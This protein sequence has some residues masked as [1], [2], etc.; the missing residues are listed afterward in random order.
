MH[1]A[2]QHAQFILLTISHDSNEPTSLECIPI[3]IGYVWNE[4]RTG[5]VGSYIKEVRHVTSKTSP[6]H[7]LDFNSHR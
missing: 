2:V 7:P 5:V 1:A 6:V 3:R 4:K